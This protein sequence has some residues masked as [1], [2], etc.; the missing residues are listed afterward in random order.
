M[1]IHAQPRSVSVYHSAQNTENQPRHSASISGASLLGGNNSS[2]FFS[3]EDSFNKSA[4]HTRELEDSLEDAAQEPLDIVGALNTLNLDADLNES[5]PLA[6]RSNEPEPIGLN[7][8]TFPSEDERVQASSVPPQR[9]LSQNILTPNAPSVAAFGGIPNTIGNPAS[10]PSYGWS[11]NFL[12]FS[13]PPMAYPVSDP[14]MTAEMAMQIPPFHL[15]DEQIGMALPIQLGGPNNNNNNGNAAMAHNFGGILDSRLAF[16]NFRTSSPDH[17]GAPNYGRFA[18]KNGDDTSETPANKTY[19]NGDTSF[20]NCQETQSKNKQLAPPQHYAGSNL[21]NPTQHPMPHFDNYL[22][23]QFNQFGQMNMISSPPNQVSG[24]LA[25]HGFGEPLNGYVCSRPGHG[26]APQHFNGNRRHH[27]HHNHHHMNG[28]VNIHRKMHNSNR[29]KGDDASK[30][31]NA[32]LEDFKGEIYSLCKDQHG[33]RFLQRQL[34]LGND[35][36][37]GENALSKDV[38][39]TMIFNELYLKIVELMVDPFGNYLIQKLFESVSADQ[40]LILVKNAAP[41]FIRIA[42]DPHGTRALQK[43]VECISTPEES[44]L[45][46]ESLSAHIVSLSRDLNGNHVVQ[47]CLQRLQPEDNQF[48]FDTASAHCGQIA[49]HRHGCCVLQ[50]CLDHGNAQ[51]R[52]QLSTKVAEIA[53]NLSLDPFGNYVVQ[54][55]LTRGDQKSITMILEHILSNIVSLSLHKFGSNVIEKSLRISHLTDT[56]I[57]VLLRNLKQFSVLLNDPFG[58]YVLQ[59]SLDVASATDLAKLATSLQPYLPNIKN[60]PHGRRILTKIQ[61]IL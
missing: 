14:A 6:S 34:D 21:W 20:E 44:S 9:L 43:L 33:C 24:Q 22:G 58:N 15:P 59:T 53:T 13:A 38:A 23:T 18:K 4:D 29:R 26:D 17:F 49:T 25:N 10:T 27:N 57:A 45:I 2:S 46:I 51:Q 56:V 50:R 30:Y 3:N 35:P 52:E 47:K 42:L 55:V 41:E 61:N 1:T 54:Y 40:R 39:A 31:A 32:K 19:A 11:N 36:S 28:G 37:A 16:E 12:P 5:L 48:I 60:T 7:R 8:A